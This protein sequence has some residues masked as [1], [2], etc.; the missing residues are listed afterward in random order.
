M[1]YP[2][3]YIGQYKNGVKPVLTPGNTI[4]QIKRVGVCGTDLHAF[5]G[6]QPYFEYPRVLG[7]ELAGE[8]VETDGAPD[9]QRGETVTF[10]P[11]VNCEHCP[12]CL[13]GKPNCCVNLKVCGVHMDGGMS[14]YLSVPSR[15]LV[16]GQGLSVDELALVEPL[17]I[18]AHGV[19]RSGV[20]K[21]E[22]ALIVGAGPIGLGAMEFSGA[23]RFDPA[24]RPCAWFSEIAKVRRK[25]PF[26]SRENI[27]TRSSTPPET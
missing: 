2:G 19:R 11:Y 17:A 22:F 10:I 16:K 13:S 4:I 1:Y 14:S 26:A 20:L 24:P 21:G 7:H 15:L 25:L 27:Y 5:D 12:A 3:K 18:G 6:T 23:A 9:F 8:I